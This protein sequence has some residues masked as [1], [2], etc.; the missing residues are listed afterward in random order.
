LW[1]RDKNVSPSP[2]SSTAT[3][4][5]YERTRKGRYVEVGRVGNYHARPDV[6]T[7]PEARHSS[8]MRCRSSIEA[9]PAIPETATISSHTTFW[10]ATAP[11]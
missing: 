6:L 8:Q 7:S 10:R 3:A 1:A 11:A 4:S 2:G 9:S 5:P